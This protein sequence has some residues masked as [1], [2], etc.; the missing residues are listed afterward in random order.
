MA[1]IYTG[2][3][4][5]IAAT[6]S[7]DCEGGCSSWLVRESSEIKREAPPPH[8]V[9]ARKSTHDAHKEVEGMMKGG[10]PSPLETRAWVYQERYLAPRTAHFHESEMMWECKSTL[11]CECGVLDNEGEVAEDMQPLHDNNFNFRKRW[12]AV[13]KTYSNMQLSN[14]RDRLPALSGIASRFAKYTDSEYLAGIWR[15]YLVQ[16][17]LWTKFR[18]LRYKPSQPHPPPKTPL[19]RRSP[20]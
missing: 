2:S 20:S 7:M 17:L 19:P 11:R 4:L 6:S 3:L 13:V 16:D 9:F 12:T 14:P 10:C 5:N 15:E 8:S 1:D 18:E